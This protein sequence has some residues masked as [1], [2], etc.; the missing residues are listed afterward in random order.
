MERNL[1][2]LGP[3]CE[4]E[5]AQGKP[6][7]RYKAGKRGLADSTQIAGDG[8]GQGG[9][10]GAAMCT[11]VGKPNLW[12]LFGC[13]YVVK[14]PTNSL[15]QQSY[16]P[17][18]FPGQSSPKHSP[19]CCTCSGSSPQAATTSLSLGKTLVFRRKIGEERNVRTWL[20]PIC[21]NSCCRRSVKGREIMPPAGAEPYC[22][23]ERGGGGVSACPELG[24][25]LQSH[26]SV[27]LSRLPSWSERPAPVPGC[28]V[29]KPVGLLRS[30]LISSAVTWGKAQN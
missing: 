26:S 18:L 22:C 1:C 8:E 14:S 2:S 19:G 9:S 17:A 3:G 5:R 6:A 13:R 10:S 4:W 23:R 21:A 28:F 12:R 11:A 27:P 25:S 20:I 24:P 30:Q 16:F 7:Q 15:D 29:R